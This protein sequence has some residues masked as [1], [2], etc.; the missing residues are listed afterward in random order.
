[1]GGLK[2]LQHVDAF[3]FQAIERG[4]QTQ[5]G[6]SHWLRPQCLHL[7]WNYLLV[8]DMPDFSSRAACAAASRAVNNRKGEQE[9]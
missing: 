2:W 6:R 8:C 4:S 9:T 3:G 7:L 1:M 5:Q